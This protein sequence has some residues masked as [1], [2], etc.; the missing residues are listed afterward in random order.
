MFQILIF[1]ISYILGSIPFGFITARLIKGIDIRKCGSGNIGATNVARVIG[2]KWGLLVF[3]LDFLKGMVPI[4]VVL[5]LY[6]GYSNRFYIGMALAAIA[7]HNWSIF[8]FFK[9]GKGVATSIGTLFGLCFKYPGLIMP[10]GVAVA[11]WII[12][13]LIY[14]KVSLASIVASFGFLIAA[15][16]SLTNEFKVVSFIIFI[17]IVIRHKKNI[18]NLLNKKELPI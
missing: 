2:R 3:I 15:I 16:F 1:V 6:P 13:F 17:L 18:S 8:L 7:G 12:I 5:S 4:I 14:R 11:I 10:I 9:G